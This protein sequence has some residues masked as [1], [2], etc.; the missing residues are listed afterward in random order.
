MKE[1][2][3]A[4]LEANRGT[5]ASLRR[6]RAIVEGSR[7]A[8]CVAVPRMAVGLS[9]AEHRRDELRAA[10][11]PTGAAFESGREA[12]ILV[13]LLFAIIAPALV[14][15]SPRTGRPA[16]DVGQGALWVG[17]VAIVG[18]ALLAS[19]ESYRPRSKYL[20]V[21]TRGDARRVY[22]TLA[23]IWLIVLVYMIASWED[24]L[25]DGILPYIGV[26]LFAL[27]LGGMIV[28]WLRARRTDRTSAP[29]ATAIATDPVD[30][31]WANAASR[32]SGREAT[33]AEQS[34]AAALDGMERLAITRPA[35]TRRLQ[36]RSPVLVWAGDSG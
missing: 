24:A 27:A 17:L 8:L 10:D 14:F 18:I 2:V 3:F 25:S 26:A 20:G 21:Q 15:P 29:S 34:Y 33:L 1:S 23:I 7:L 28:L 32:M 16:L 13:G 4:E 31:W 35:D 36:R 9:A 6:S 12:A 30:D 11:G 5:L 19:Q 22:L